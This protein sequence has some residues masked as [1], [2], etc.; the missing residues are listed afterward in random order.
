MYSINVASLKETDVCE[1]VCFTGV[2]TCS[3]RPYEDSHGLHQQHQTNGTG[4]LLCPYN[5][6]QNL[7]LECP[8]HAVRHA[9]ENTEDYQSWIV[10]GLQE[11]DGRFMKMM[12]FL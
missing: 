11:R 1:N 6:H 4:E 3:R 12:T 7:K 5:S 10:V 8:H 2:L 9:K